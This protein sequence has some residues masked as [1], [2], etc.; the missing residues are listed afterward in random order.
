MQTV[1]APAS[2]EVSGNRR[3][4]ILR[5]VLTPERSVKWMQHEVDDQCVSSKVR[6]LQRFAQPG[7]CHDFFVSHCLV[8]RFPVSG[9]AVFFLIQTSILRFV[10]TVAP[11]GDEAVR[12]DAAVITAVAIIIGASERSED[13]LQRFRSKRGNSFCQPGKIRDPEH[14][15]DAVAPRLSGQPVDQVA[16]IARLHRAHELIES[17]R[18]AAAAHVENRVHIPA[19]GVESRIAAFHIAAHRREADG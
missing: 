6:I 5:A 7:H 14:S 1:I 17:F 16:D 12:Q 4:I 2:A 19:P 18:A 3:L 10:Q 13:R 15:D 11:V 9:F 8:D